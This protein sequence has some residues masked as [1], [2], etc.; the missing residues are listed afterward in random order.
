MLY[1]I[2]NVLEHTQQCI[3]LMRKHENIGYIWN[4]MLTNSA[5]AD[6]QIESSRRS[7]FLFEHR[8]FPRPV[9]TFWSDAPGY[10]ATPDG[11]LDELI[12]LR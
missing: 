4:D 1:K 3:P 2:D 12:I 8:I 11:F 5:A 9:P 10:L 7:I 6:V